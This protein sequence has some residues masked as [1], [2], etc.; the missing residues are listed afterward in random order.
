MQ[1]KPYP[2]VGVA[3]A[4]SRG[5]QTSKR[6]CGYCGRLVAAHV[7]QCPNCR[8][9]LP[10]TRSAG[11]GSTRRTGGRGQIR[12]G[13]LYMLLATVIYYF[14]GGHIPIKLPFSISPGV[15]A[16]LAPLL[17]LAGLGLVLFGLFFRTDP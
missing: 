10:P 1:Q 14:A 13:L 8:E 15:M 6:Q 4:I 11:I 5:G 16:H 3:P 9:A 12:R 2:S 17:F 7:S